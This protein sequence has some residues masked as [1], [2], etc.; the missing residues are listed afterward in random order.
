MKQSIK[1]A[2]TITR[3]RAKALAKHGKNAF[4]LST[5]GCSAAPDFNFSDCCKEH[6]FAYRNGTQSRYA[7]DW[8]LAK[9]IW[10]KGHPDIAIIYYLVVRAVG[11]LSYNYA[12]RKQFT[13]SHRYFP[14]YDQILWVSFWGLAFA[15]VLSLT[16]MLSGCSTPTPFETGREVPAPTGCI[17]M[18]SRGGEC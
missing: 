17:E 12:K 8:D 11:F 9:C 10:H 7:A 2:F 18:R 5:D 14:A 1:A 13:K 4:D 15:C 16:L 6:D 3:A